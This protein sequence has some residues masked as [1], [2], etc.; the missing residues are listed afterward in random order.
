M[1]VPTP[2][3]ID[4]YVNQLKAH[5]WFYDYSD[6]HVVWVKGREQANKLS[7]K[8]MSHEAYNQIYRMWKDTVINRTKFNDV[9]AHRT[10][11][12][13]DIKAA[14]ATLVH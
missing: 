5:D 13:E 9:I 14:V 4:E 10:A 7:A 3:Q 12:V 11:Y 6:D 2:Y 1:N 8:A